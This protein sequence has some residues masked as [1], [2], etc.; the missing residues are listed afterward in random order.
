MQSLRQRFG[1]LLP[2]GLDHATLRVVRERSELLSVRLGVVQPPERSDD[3]GA[4]VTVYE[5]GGMGYAA[6]SDLGDAGLLDAIERARAWARRSAALSAVDWSTAAP[7]PGDGQWR[8]PLQTP[9]RDVSLDRKLALLHDADAAL[10]VNDRIALHAATLW[11]TRTEIALY[12]AAG[13]A[14]E[15]QTE[16]LVPDLMAVA[17]VGT[18]AATRTLSGRGVCR[19]GGFE[20]LDGVDLVAEAARVGEE[21]TALLEA[22]PC[23]VGTMDLV[24]DP[25]QMLLQ[26]HESIGHPLELDR[27]LGDERNYAGTSFVTPEMF[28]SYRYGSELLNVTFAP[29]V[30]GEFASYGFDD[31]GAPAERAWLIR[32]GILLRPLGSGVSGARSGLPAVANA[33]ATSWNRPPI[34]RMANLNLEAGDASMADLIGGVERGVLMQ[35]NCSWSIDDSRNKFQFGCELGWRIEDGELREMVRTPCYRGVSATFWRS[36]DGV[37]DAST[38]GVYGSPYCGKGEPN[39]VVRVG[40][41]SPACRFRDVE[42]FGAA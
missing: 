14:I 38:V 27:I 35:T 19:Q 1:A 41:A 37:G 4:M 33:R 7:R 22:A 16:L 8:G 32:D 21:A 6:T 26:I 30:Q 10:G 42:V 24:L 36:L 15:Q 9:W 25:D 3:L 2:S 23:P 34:D 39:Q 29:D 40:H 31:D 11:H 12:D 5:G 20:I 18:D 28:G 13:H 17:S